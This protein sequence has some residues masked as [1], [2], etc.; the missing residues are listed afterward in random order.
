MNPDDVTE[1]V[2]SANKPFTRAEVRDL[3]RDLY[4][5]GYDDGLTRGYELAQIEA[6][7][8]ADND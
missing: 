3:M 1:W 5:A 7:L 4:N 2:M 8:A 6:A